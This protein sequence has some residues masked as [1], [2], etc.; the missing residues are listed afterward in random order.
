MSWRVGEWPEEGTANYYASLVQYDRALRRSEG[1]RLVGDGPALTFSEGNATLK[2]DKLGY[3][4]YAEVS[5]GTPSLSFLVALDTGSDLFW[6][7]CDCVSCATTSL[8]NFGVNFKLNTYSPNS[9]LT[10]KKVTCNSTLCQPETACIESSGLCPYKVAYISSDTASSGL[11][12]ED[13]MYLTT[14]D[15]RGEST[16]ARVTFGCGQVQ[17]GSFLDSAAPNGLFGLGLEKISVPSI[18]ASSGLVSNSFSMCF[19]LDGI[20]R[21]SFGDKGSS[22]QDETPFSIDQLPSPT[23]VVCWTSSRKEFFH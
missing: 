1:R 6:V 23:F 17:S 11:L 20:G 19:G 16:R 13:V 18:L 4:H 10:S 8:R 9:S 5:I 2:I 12:V 7:P 22:D 15:S 3:L 14:E 21:I